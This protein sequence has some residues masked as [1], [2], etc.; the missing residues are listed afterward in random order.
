[1]KEYY[2]SNN[3]EKK[4]RRSAPRYPVCVGCHGVIVPVI[5]E[6][7]QTIPER[8]LP[9]HNNECKRLFENPQD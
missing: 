5:G 4:E 3:P 7:I 1:M 8:D 6:K 2:L 9:V